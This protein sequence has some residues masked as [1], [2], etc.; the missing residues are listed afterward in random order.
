MHNNT[1]S[2]EDIALLITVYNRSSSLERLLKAFDELGI[3]FGEIIVSD[4]CSKAQHQE[5]MKL[6]QQDYPFKLIT[7]PINK[8][9]ANNLNKGQNA[10]TK[11]FTLYVQE[12]F[13]PQ[14]VFIKNLEN[15]VKIIK[16]D[17]SVDTIRFYAYFPYPYTKP[18]DI[19]FDEMIFKKSILYW[20]HLKFYVYSDHPHLRRSNFLKKFG[21]YK[22]GIQ[23]D[24]T[25]FEMA[26]SF[27]KGNGKG[28]IAKDIYA[29]FEQKN[30]PD[31]PSTVNRKSWREDKSLIILG[32]RKVFLLYRFLKNTFQ[33][34][35]K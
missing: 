28:L 12:D 6:L 7:T 15:A 5:K 34:Y 33:L 11:P 19:N 35:S 22:E 29:S 9:L 26:L 24:K 32:L 16:E 2:F 25:E 4:D 23:M 27:I 1:Y 30:S 20:N 18:Y 8:G 14:P 10:V 21:Y 17:T 13:I 31:E 3:C